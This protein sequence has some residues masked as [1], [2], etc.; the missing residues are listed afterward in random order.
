MESA[1]P[2]GNFY[3]NLNVSFDMSEEM[4]EVERLDGLSTQPYEDSEEAMWSDDLDVELLESMEEGIFNRPR[5]TN[6][7]EKES[8]DQEKSQPEPDDNVVEDEDYVDDDDD[9]P[10]SLTSSHNRFAP[11]DDLQLQNFIDGQR[12]QS[13]TR[14]T[15]GHMK[16]FSLYLASKK[17]NRP[18]HLLEPTEL[19]KHLALFFVTVR[20]HDKEDRD[21]EPTTMKSMQSS[22]ERY[23]K[24]KKSS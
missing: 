8:E 1:G 14:K 17:E 10:A 21:Y 13:T 22:I 5:S 18:A 15:V 19:N 16:L 23:L 24:E 6:Q 2:L 20:K 3:V 7:P 4:N 9:D 12:N 11:M